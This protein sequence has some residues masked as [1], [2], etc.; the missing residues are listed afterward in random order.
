MQKPSAGDHNLIYRR[1]QNFK[2][3]YMKDFFKRLVEEQT[4]LEEKI[5]KLNM[6]IRSENF[7]TLNVENR[8]LLRTQL[9]TM[10]TYDLI[11]KRRIEINKEI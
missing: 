8:S 3:V 1:P 6:F 2:V 9:R 5:F 11:L 4:E 10:Q 7:S